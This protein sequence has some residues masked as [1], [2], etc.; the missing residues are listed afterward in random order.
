MQ[1]TA[2]FHTEVIYNCENRSAILS[3]LYQTYGTIYSVE[4]PELSLTENLYVV[5]HNLGIDP[6][7]PTIEGVKH[8]TLLRNFTKIKIHKLIYDTFLI[9]LLLGQKG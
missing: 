9:N 2:F 1:S 4:S 7:I 8:I 6:R 5:F 3:K